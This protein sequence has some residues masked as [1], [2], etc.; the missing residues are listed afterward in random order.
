MSSAKMWYM[1]HTKNTYVDMMKEAMYIARDLMGCDAMSTCL[2]GP[3]NPEVLFDE[4]KF[5]PTVQPMNWYMM[6]YSFGER[7]VK[8]EDMNYI[9]F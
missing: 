2:V 6:N 4:L 3:H 8:P 5:K 7:H 1:A 9:M